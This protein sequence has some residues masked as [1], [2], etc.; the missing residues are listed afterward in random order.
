MQAFLDLKGQGINL[1]GGQGLAE[2]SGKSANER[3][4]NRRSRPQPTCDWDVRD[5]S[6]SHRRDVRDLER[7]NHPSHGDRQGMVAGEL[8]QIGVKVDVRRLDANAAMPWFTR[9]ATWSKR[10][11]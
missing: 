11:S 5:D 10:A 6:Q 3:H 1:L 2:E 4:R 8:I 9:L 7:R